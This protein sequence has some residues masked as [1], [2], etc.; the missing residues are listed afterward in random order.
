MV[1]KKRVIICCGGSGGHFFPGLAVAHEIERLGGQP[2]LWI[3]SRLIDL[4]LVSRFANSIKTETLPIEG[5]K[6]NKPLKSVVQFIKAFLKTK[7]QFSL[8]KPYAVFSTGGFTG[9]PVGL[10]CRL[11][12]I[13]LFLFE[14]N[15]I[16][17]RANL[18]LQYFAHKI[19]VYF[20]QAVGLFKTNKVEKCGFPLRPRNHVPMSK[21][22]ACLTFNLTLKSPVILIVGGSSGAKK[23]NELVIQSVAL[24]KNVLGEFQIIHSTGVNFSKQVFELYNKLNIRAY[25]ADFID[26]I[27]T[28]L[29]AADIAVSRAGACWLADLATNR[30]PALLIPLS[31]L[32]GDHQVA[33]ARCF[34]DSGAALWLHEK[35][36]V[37]EKL[38][39]LIRTILFDNQKR[40]LLRCSLAQWDM[41]NGSTLIARE[42]LK[43]IS[44]DDK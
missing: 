11:Y 34:A 41:P 27:D 2:E 1:E 36:A 39:N 6:E 15:A 16:P 7:V 8:E 37:P 38:V 43:Q 30:L 33:N 44:K 14:A 29:I 24:L 22:E 9:I 5:L 19:W 35:D 32:A 4:K 13:P 31:G 17:G 3:S 28:A 25:V 10:V 18:F 42:L 20:P 12:K 26:K 23:L 40:F 21:R